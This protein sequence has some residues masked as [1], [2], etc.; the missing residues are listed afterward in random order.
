[1]GEP[2]DLKEDVPDD[3]LGLPDDRKEDPFNT[4]RLPV[5]LKEGPGD[6]SEPLDDL[7]KSFDDV[8]ELLDD[9]PGDAFLGL[10]GDL[11]DDLLEDCF[12]QLLSWLFFWTAA[13]DTQP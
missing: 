1:M 3:T 10:A 4:F 2:G 8:L 6:V 13:Q 12:A 5:D 11:G 9:L 7:E